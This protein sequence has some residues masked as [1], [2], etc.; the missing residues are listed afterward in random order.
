[1]N[2]LLSRGPE[3]GQKPESISG[4]PESIS[5]RPESISAGPE[6]IS[7]WPE[8]ISARPESISARPESISGIFSDLLEE[9]CTIYVSLASD[10]IIPG[11]NPLS[12]E[13]TLA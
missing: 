12:P 10:Y 9:D 6:S 11:L 8:S 2:P 7:A 13:S 3:F 4:I 1:M 5:A